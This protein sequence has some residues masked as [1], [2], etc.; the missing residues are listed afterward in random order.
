MGQIA[1]YVIA[2]LD[3][4]LDE[5]CEREKRYDWALG[6]KSAKTGRRAMLP[7]DAVWESRKLIAEIDEDQHRQSMPFWDK[8]DTLTVSGVD[9]GQQ[10]RLYDDRTRSAARDA[11]YVVL[12]IPWP[13]RRPPRDRDRAADQEALVAM[14]AG[15]GVPC[16]T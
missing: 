12:E 7:F 8:P 13:R 15:V 4:I 1:D 16:Q 11:G 6:D 10:R 5:P 9:R 14:L 2:L 3:E